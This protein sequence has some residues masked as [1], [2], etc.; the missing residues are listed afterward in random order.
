MILRN[1]DIKNLKV[2]GSGHTFNEIADTVEGGALLSLVNMKDITVTEG[3]ISFGAGCIYYDLIKA[4]DASNQAIPN[5]PSLPHI[6]VVGSMVTTTHG[7]GHNQPMMVA[8]VTNYDIVFA[9]GTLKTM[10]KDVDPN[11]YYYIHSFGGVGIISRMSLRLI[12]R[13]NVFKAIYKNLSWDS[14]KAD[15]AF[16]ALEFGSDYLSLFNDWNK[17]EFTSVW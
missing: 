16:D 15:A 2:Q 14:I 12:P 4:A 9:D 17:R 3:E 5:L 13:F 8:H 10:Y 1:P 11:F 7:S 6:N